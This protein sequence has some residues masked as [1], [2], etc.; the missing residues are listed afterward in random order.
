MSSKFLSV[1]FF[2]LA[3]Q[4]TSVNNVNQPSMLQLFAPL[5]IVFIIF[6]FIAI[7][8]RQKEQKEREQMLRN[9]KKYDKVMTIGGIIGTIIE[10][11]DNEVILKVDDNT[12]T[13]MKFAKSAIQK[14]LGSEDN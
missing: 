7:R 9:L 10:V 6:Y 8:P 1:A 2:T 13:R 11:R 5:I 14:V 4:S 12:N 3:Q